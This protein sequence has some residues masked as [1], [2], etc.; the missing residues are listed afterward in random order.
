MDLASAFNVPVEFKGPDGTVY[1]LRKPTIYE[2][3]EYQRWLESRAHDAVDRSNASEEQKVH[4]HHLIDVDAG[5]GKYEW[6]G[7]LAL[8]SMW[9]PAG[10]A[11]LLTILCRDQK[12]DDK[13]AEEILETSARIIAAHVLTKAQA[14]PKARADLSLMLGAMGLPM[15]WLES[16]QSEPSSDSSST[17]PSPDPSEN[18]ETAPTTN[19]SFFT[20]SSAAPTG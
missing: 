16:E 14:D 11:K 4:R 2:Q 7:L 12:V 6:D 19:S 9:Q 15:D 18:S 13:K 1:K 10:V 20:T 5:L 3:G 17:P 8:E